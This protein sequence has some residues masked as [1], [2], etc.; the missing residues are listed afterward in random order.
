VLVLKNP[1]SDEKGMTRE[2]LEA[3]WSDE[4]KARADA[5]TYRKW[6][7]LKGWRASCRTVP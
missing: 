3:Q 2:K 1:F 6:Q 5:L 4:G 7:H